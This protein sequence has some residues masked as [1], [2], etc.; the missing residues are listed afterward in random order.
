MEVNER[1]EKGRQVIRS[2]AIHERQIYQHGGE[3]RIKEQWYS[4]ASIDLCL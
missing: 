1:P 3:M 2:I 4:S